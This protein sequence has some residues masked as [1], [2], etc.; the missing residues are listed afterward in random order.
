MIAEIR[1]IPGRQPVG[2]AYS[3]IH[4]GTPGGRPVLMYFGG[5]HNSHQGNDVEIFDLRT[6]TWER[7]YEPEFCP[8]TDERCMV[9][10]GGSAVNFLSPLGRPYVQHTYQMIAW[11]QSRGGF[12]CH[13]R[14]AGTFLYRVEDASWRALAGPHAPSSPFVPFGGDVHTHGLVSNDPLPIRAILTMPLPKGGV[15]EL[16]RSGWERIAENPTEAWSTPY[17]TWVPEWRAHLVRCWDKWWVLNEDL[18]W[19]GIAGGPD[20]DSFDYGDGCVLGMRHRGQQPVE[21]RVLGLWSNAH[22][23]DDAWEQV[24]TTGDRAVGLYGGDGATAPVLRYDPERNRWIYLQVDVGEDGHGGPCRTFEV[25]LVKT[26][27]SKREGRV[28]QARRLLAEA[29]A[30]L[31]EAE[32]VLAEVPD[33]E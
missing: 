2:R 21:V 24:Q 20:L 28:P 3:G 25:K 31:I 18:S 23:W 13:L 17:S 27:V 16:R 26:A 32:E 33:D 9:I 10:R 15:W 22:L 8:E 7:Q 4:Y 30:A 5:A 1:E 6:N 19:A 12:V 11:D 14:P 29:R